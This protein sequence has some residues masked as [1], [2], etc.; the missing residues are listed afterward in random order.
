MSV[1]EPAAISVVNR[2]ELA[3]LFKVSEPTVDRWVKAGCPVVEKGRRGEPYRF[4]AKAVLDWRQ[5]VE[6]E[7]A[8]ESEARRAQLAQLQL[9][10]VGGEA[11]EGG[12]VLTADQRLKA[13]QAELFANRLGR[14][15]GE[16]VEAEVVE[17]EFEALFALLRQRLLALPA[18]LACRAR[19]G[20]G[21][22]AATPW[23]RRSR[24]AT[25]CLCRPGPAVPIDAWPAAGQQWTGGDSNAI[26]S[27]P[28]ISFLVGQVGRMGRTYSI[29]ILKGVSVVGFQEGVRGPKIGI[30]GERI[31][32]IGRI[33][34]PI[35]PLLSTS[36]RNQ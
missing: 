11:P 23:G 13:I 31:K 19:R 6:R 24:L 30:A 26:T 15:R 36:E 33:C 18:L 22:L 9:E 27:N 3:G 7:E 8:E 5:G 12:P 17:R 10:L 35:R 20:G 34:C 28:L 29:R 32:N 25:R 16:L 14:E 2:G 1:A 4:D 21:E